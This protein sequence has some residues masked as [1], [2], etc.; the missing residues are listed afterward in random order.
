M[1]HSIGRE[2]KEMGSRKERRT[3]DMRERAKKRRLFKRSCW[4]KR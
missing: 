4:K 2:R 1:R 3:K